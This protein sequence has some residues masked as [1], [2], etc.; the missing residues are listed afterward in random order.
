MEGKASYKTLK[1]WQKSIDLVGIIYK[2][3]DQFPAREQY[4][5]S[6]QM[7]RAAISVPSNI[8]EGWARH[9]KLEFIRYLEIA[10]AS[11][12]ELDTQII[13]AQSRYPK[14]DYTAALSLLLEVQKMLASFIKKVKITHY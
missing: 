9:R 8:A 14:I 7:I 3:T 10:F 1:V 13:I 2:I 4:V 5:I 11:S 12:C 6:S